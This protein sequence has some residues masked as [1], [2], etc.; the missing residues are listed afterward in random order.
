MT[1]ELLNIGDLV[2]WCNP[3]KPFDVDE[4]CCGV[5]V[6]IITDTD[7]EIVYDVDWFGYS[8]TPYRKEFLMRIS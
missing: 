4:N 5:V 3:N 2:L 7:G 1:N 8:T 6:K